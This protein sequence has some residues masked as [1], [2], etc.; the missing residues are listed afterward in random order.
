MS[1]R[2]AVVGTGRMGKLHARVLSQMEDA[3]LVCVVD[4]DEANAKDVAGQR[5]CLAF[6]D[7]NDA[8]ELVDA[9]IIAVPTLHH[10]DAARPFIE[11]GK[12]VL[13]EKPFTDD[14]KA[15]RKL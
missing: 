15:G 7:V 8:V 13:I 1:F 4:A 11:A 12:S 14:V 6:T 9:A 2:V 10:L 3:E 5:D